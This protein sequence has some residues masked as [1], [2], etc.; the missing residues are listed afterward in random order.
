MIIKKYAT[1]LALCLGMMATANSQPMPEFVDGHLMETKTINWGPIMVPYIFGQY[2]RV[3]F[4]SLNDGEKSK[5]TWNDTDNWSTIPKLFGYSLTTGQCF[6]SFGPCAAP[7]GYNYIVNTLEI[8]F[9]PDEIAE[10]FI[11]TLWHRSIKEGGYKEVILADV[12]GN[13]QLKRTFSFD[14]YVPSSIRVRVTKSPS[15]GKKPAIVEMATFWQPTPPPPPIPTP[16][17]SAWINHALQG[18]PYIVEGGNTNSRIH[19]PVLTDGNSYQKGWDGIG[20]WSSFSSVAKYVVDFSAACQDNTGACT[21]RVK[22]P[23][24][25]TI[26]NVILYSAQD[27]V[28]PSN[29]GLFTQY[30]AQDITV[31]GRDLDSSDPTQLVVL[32]EVKGN[33]QVVRNIRLAR[34]YRLG[35]LEV[36]AKQPAGSARTK[37]ALVEIQAYNR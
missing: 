7:Y 18:I 19:Y 5:K 8:D 20:D 6:D 15:D 23:T 4:P 24:V 28:P 2:S 11:I 14:F 30:G 3:Y 1:A 27:D 21:S 31:M 12:K 37:P 34:P 35:S 29:P 36:I 10:D 32:A 25:P 16:V 26:N 33:N 13:T 9:N 22:T 17:N